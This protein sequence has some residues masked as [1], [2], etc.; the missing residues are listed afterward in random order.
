ML[1]LAKAGHC[2]VRYLHGKKQVQ[3]FS[4]KR[5]HE[6]EDEMINLEEE[7]NN[8]DDGTFSP[9]EDDSTVQNFN[10]GEVHNITHNEVEVPPMRP[11]RPRE[12]GR[13]YYNGIPKSKDFVQ[14]VI[15]PGQ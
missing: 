4:I 2:I 8:Y 7:A 13:Q 3:A 11:L 5:I 10:F 6:Y 14:R 9:D 15:G 1:W 12:N